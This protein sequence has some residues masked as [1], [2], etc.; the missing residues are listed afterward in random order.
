MLRNIPK[1]STNDLRGCRKLAE[2]TAL[3]AEAADEAAATE[4]HQ[5]EEQPR[6]SEGEVAAEE[7]GAAP[8][9]AEPSPP[10]WHRLFGR[11]VVPGHGAGGR[12]RPPARGPSPRR[13]PGLPS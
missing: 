13:L 5:K 4:R 6:E 2:A 1:W 10:A 8:P 3:A 11:R 12:L 9:R 7:A